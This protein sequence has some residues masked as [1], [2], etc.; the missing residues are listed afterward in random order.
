MFVSF[1]FNCDDFLFSKKL[2]PYGH[3]S[4][5]SPRIT[6][7]P[8][9]TKR[10]S[11]DFDASLRDFL[12]SLLSPRPADNTTPKTLEFDEHTR[13][14]GALVVAADTHDPETPVV[15]ETPVVNDDDLHVD[16]KGG[17]NRDKKTVSR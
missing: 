8:R 16:K 15:A 9:K 2:V 5:V 4:H 17:L 14:S 12:S 11:D 1:N 13:D 3:F 6:G 10:S 7:S